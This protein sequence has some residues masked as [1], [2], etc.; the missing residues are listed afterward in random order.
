MVLARISYLGI[1]LSAFS[2]YQQFYPQKMIKH[3]FLLDSVVGTKDIKWMR[4]NFCPQGIWISAS[5]KIYQNLL[6]AK[7]KV[8]FWKIWS[9]NMNL[10]RSS[11]FGQL[12]GHLPT[13]SL[14]SWASSDWDDPTWASL[15]VLLP[16]ETASTTPCSLSI[17]PENKSFQVWN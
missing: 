1:W 3:L 10:T 2:S 14:Y 16:L 15:S 6:L 7:L 4:Q 11:E 17:G 9:F 8:S 13:H 12:K 5:I